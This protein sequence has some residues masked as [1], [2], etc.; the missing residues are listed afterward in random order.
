ME[1]I[2]NNLDVRIPCGREFGS[3]LIDNGVIVGLTSRFFP[4]KCYDPDELYTVALAIKVAP[5]IPWIQSVM[6]PV[7]FVFE[8]ATNCP[9]DPHEFPFHLYVYEERTR[10]CSATLIHPQW[11]ITSWFCLS[12]KH[13]LA[14]T[15]EPE[16]L[17]GYSFLNNTY[18]LR[19][20]ESD[21]AGHEAGFPVLNHQNFFVHRDRRFETDLLVLVRL[22]EPM[23]TPSANLI[24]ENLDNL[25]EGMW[26]W[27]AFGLKCDRRI[28]G[29]LKKY[30]SSMREV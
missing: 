17:V 25:P 18:I 4:E 23:Q 20:V 11:I 19:H 12:A 5:Y 26:V 29:V 8:N 28:S 22:R 2:V 3:P 6:N 9:K 30:G 13:S 10:T 21:W 24:L 27:G 15:S 16:V 1:E 14:G 7:E